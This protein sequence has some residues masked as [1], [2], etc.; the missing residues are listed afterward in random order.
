MSD[1]RIGTW[2]LNVVQSKYSPGPAPQSLMVKVEAAAGQGEKTTTDFG[3]SAE[4]KTK[5]ML[6]PDP[7]TELQNTTDFV[8]M[9]LS[10]VTAAQEDEWLGSSAS[11]NMT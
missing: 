6:V 11:T 9:R 8:L 3:I 2:K 4:M 7:N 10:S 5:T 1:P